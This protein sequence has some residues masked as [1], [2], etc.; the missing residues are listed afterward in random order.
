MHSETSGFK[1]DTTTRGFWQAPLLLDKPRLAATIYEVFGQQPLTKENRF[2]GERKSPDSGPGTNMGRREPAFDRWVYLR[3]QFSALSEEGERK[4]FDLGCTSEM[5]RGLGREKVPPV[6]GGPGHLT[7]EFV[8]RFEALATRA[9]LDLEVP[10]GIA[11][12][13]FWLESVER[14]T[15]SWFSD[16]C[17]ASAEFCSHLERRALEKAADK[18]SA[19]GRPR[20]DEE[21]K[22]VRE[23]KEAGKTWKEIAAKM[24][25]DTGQDKSPGAYRS[26]LS[27]PRTRRP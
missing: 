12:L 25:E 19:V 11:P 13:R 20:K 14:N 6:W 18:S 17:E 24:N 9:A 2:R 15:N 3:D 5:D 4:K 22:K 16:W 8:A 23:M 1:R 26:L 10:K 21:R 7:D 27:R